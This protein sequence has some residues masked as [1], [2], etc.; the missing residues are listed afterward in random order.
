V[1][2]GPKISFSL[3]PGAGSGSSGGKPSARVKLDTGLEHRA[4]KPGGEYAQHRKRPTDETEKAKFRE[5][6]ASV[7]EAQQHIE[8]TKR[9]LTEEWPDDVTPVH[10]LIPTVQAINWDHQ[11]SIPAEKIDWSRQGEPLRVR[12]SLS[13]II[14]LITLA[15]AVLGSGAAFYWGVRMHQENRQIHVP[16]DTGIPWGV[17]AKFETRKEAVEAR[18]KL[19]TAIGDAMKT[20]HARLKEDIVKAL[21]R[22][23]R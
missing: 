3:M 9:R 19:V 13:Q 21:K 8:A 16:L 17:G 12:L 10:D 22:R 2:D 5:A 23:R 14:T 18:T 20:E 11:P 6:W 1:G 4:V 7:Q 15:V